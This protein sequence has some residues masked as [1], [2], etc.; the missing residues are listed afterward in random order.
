MNDII[1]VEIETWVL[2][3]YQGTR[4]ASIRRDSLVGAAAS[5]DLLGLTKKAQEMTD[6]LAKLPGVD[7]VEVEVMPEDEQ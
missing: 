5:G 2:G 4:K 3:Q 6:A 7:R 1:E